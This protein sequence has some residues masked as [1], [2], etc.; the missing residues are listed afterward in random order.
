[1]FIYLPENTLTAEKALDTI[2]LKRVIMDLIKVK[3]LKHLANTLLE[4]Y[5]L[6]SEHVW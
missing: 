2:I 4:L 5:I 1:M 6:K 3:L